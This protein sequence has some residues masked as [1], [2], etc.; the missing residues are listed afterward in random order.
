MTR[1]NKVTK[2][3]VKKSTPVAIPTAEVVAPEPLT[4]KVVFAEM[5]YKY[6]Q[7]EA[8]RMGLKANGTTAD[9]IERLA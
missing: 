5:S 3:S 2:R 9:L 7:A 4:G 1:I 8:K 6:L